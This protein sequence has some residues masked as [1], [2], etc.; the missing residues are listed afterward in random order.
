MRELRARRRHVRLQQMPEAEVLLAGVPGRQLAPSLL[1]LRGHCLAGCRGSA[2]AAAVEGW[3]PGARGAEERGRDQDYLRAEHAEP[4]QGHRR[5]P[6]RAEACP[7]EGHRNAG[8]QGLQERTGVCKDARKRGGRRREAAGAAAAEEC[9]WAACPA[10]LCRSQAAGE[11][12]HCEGARGRT[13]VPL[14]ASGQ[15]RPLASCWRAHRRRPHAGHSEASERDQRGQQPP[16]QHFE[17]WARARPPSEGAGGPGR[18]GD[19]QRCGC[20]PCNG[21]GSGRNGGSGECRWF[22][23]KERWAGGELRRD[24]GDSCWGWWREGCAGLSC[25]R[26]GIGG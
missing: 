6:G 12:C 10:P 14:L 2:A 4:P 25:S 16:S 18:P 7:A 13:A 21:G 20:R 5:P 9:A 8:G 17:P 26:G 22:G 1:R 19:A 15:Q 23:G 3:H 11:W 24:R